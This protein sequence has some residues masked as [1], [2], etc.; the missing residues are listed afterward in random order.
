MGR[1]PLV[2][3]AGEDQGYPGCDAQ[4]PE[5]D[6]VAAEGDGVQWTA[7]AVEVS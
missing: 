3:D 6:S 7:A 1:W 2:F 5:G 4:E